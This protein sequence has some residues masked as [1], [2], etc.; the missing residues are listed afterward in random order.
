MSVDLLH[1]GGDGLE[2]V[3]GSGDGS[4]KDLAG[5]LVACGSGRHLSGGG[6]VDQTL[7]GLAVLSGEEDELGLVGVETL[8]VKL[9]LLLASG[10]SS[11][12]DR[13]A[14]GASEGGA[15]AGGLELSQSEAT[16]IS[17]LASIPA[18]ARGHN[19]SELL[20]G[21]GEHF[22]AFLLSA[23]QSSELLRWL[24]EVDSDARLPVLAEMYV[25]DDV[26]VLDHC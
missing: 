26:V 20:G 25:W 10:G 24:V 21:P 13:D 15:E 1:V 11:V 3:L 7:L 19:R 4:W 2:L 5:D 16:A 6:V 9:E 23:L 14:D 17:D 18:G 22:T 8:S 12:V